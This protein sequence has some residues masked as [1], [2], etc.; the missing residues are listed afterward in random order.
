MALNDPNHPKRQNFFE[1]PVPRTSMSAWN[2]RRTVSISKPSQARSMAFSLSSD[3]DSQYWKKL[4]NFFDFLFKVNYS[5]N[6][7]VSL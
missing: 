2:N 6:I 1:A 4:K 3:G 5:N 7:Y